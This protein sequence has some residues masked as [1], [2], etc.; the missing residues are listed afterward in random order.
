MRRAGAAHRPAPRGPPHRPAP[1]TGWARSA[2]R[3]GHRRHRTPPHASG[4]SG[5]RSPYGVDGPAPWGARRPRRRR[6][7]PPAR[8]PERRRCRNRA[9]MMGSV[10]SV[11]WTRCHALSGCPGLRR[12]HGAGTRLCS[13]RGSRKVCVLALRRRPAGEPRDPRVRRRVQ[14]R[15]SPASSA[16]PRPRF[17]HRVPVRGARGRQQYSTPQPLWRAKPPRMTNLNLHKRLE[18][19]MLESVK[20]FSLRAPTLLISSDSSTR[21]VAIH[22]ETPIFLITTSER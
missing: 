15:T 6:R 18:S 1:R 11:T 13:R 2:G 3:S 21:S 17:G 10:I 9:G 14:R 8:T 16:R 7:R 20:H 5:T 4:P 19:M 22:T 12:T